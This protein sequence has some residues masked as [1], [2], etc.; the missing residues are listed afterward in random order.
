[1][2]DNTIVTNEIFTHVYTMNCPAKTYKHCNISMYM[3]FNVSI[4]TVYT[5]YHNLFIVSEMHNNIEGSLSSR[6]IL[7]MSMTKVIYIHVYMI[8]I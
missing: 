6:Y 4:Y 7:Q 8:N 3:H 1:M 5:T 2:E